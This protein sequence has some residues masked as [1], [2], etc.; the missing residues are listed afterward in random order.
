ML[1]KK[2]IENDFTIQLFLSDCYKG[3]WYFMRTKHPDISHE[4]NVCHLSKSLIKKLKT[5]EKIV[6]CTLVESEH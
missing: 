6:R 1:L 3:I 4:F 2:L 5:L